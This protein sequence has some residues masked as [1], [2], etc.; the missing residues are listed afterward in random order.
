ML[1]DETAG[2][3]AVQAWPAVAEEDIPWGRAFRTV[4]S[5]GDFI[6]DIPGSTVQRSPIPAFVQAAIAHAHFE[7]IHPFPMGTD[8]PAER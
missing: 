5:R 6:D 3:A 8:A 1:P 2:S 7:T 4:S